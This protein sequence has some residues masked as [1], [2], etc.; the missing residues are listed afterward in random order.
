MVDV[1]VAPPVETR[2]TAS[3][4]RAALGN[5]LAMVGIIGCGLLLLVAVF[6]PMLAPYDPI[7]QNILARFAAPSAAHWLGADE[8]GRD[9]LSRILYASRASIFI[10]LSSVIISL[11]LGVALGILAAYHGGIL[12]ALLSELAS[13]LLAFPT[14]V[15][16][17]LVLVSLGPGSFNVVIAL[18]LSFVPRFIRLAKAEALVIMQR[19]FVEAS[20]AAGAR[21]VWIMFKHILPNVVG[22]AIVSGA[23]WTATALRAEATLSFLGLGV[24][25]PWPSWGNLVADGMPNMFSN[26]ELVLFPCLAIVFAVIAFNILGDALR[27]YFDPHL[28]GR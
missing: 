23:L 5:P 13:L 21:D 2:G 22:T 7:D 12:D 1:P 24:P 25:L 20:R 26:P 9:M 19:S 11:V 8:Y 28:A 6:G 14:I 3:A 17:I 4:L 15:I 18:A 16:G 10:A 27:D